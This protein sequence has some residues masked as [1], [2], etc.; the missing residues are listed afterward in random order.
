[1]ATIHLSLLALALYLGAHTFRCVRLYV[2]S[3]GERKGGARLVA[4]HCLTVWANAVI[5]F[6]L[7]EILRIAGFGA[8]M[9][10]PTTGGSIWLIERFSDAVAIL[11]VV[12]GVSLFFP[13]AQDTMIALGVAGGFIL[14]SCLGAWVLSEIVPFLR[15]DLIL[16]RFRTAGHLKRH[17]ET[18]EWTSR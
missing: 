16:E 2:L 3:L 17:L 8:A 13:P 7:G 4:A 6:K 14:A 5:P 15:R 18:L 1:M 12:G 11:V 9:K 10:S